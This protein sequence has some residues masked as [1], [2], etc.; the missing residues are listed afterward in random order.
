MKPI[1]ASKVLFIKLGR[2]GHWETDCLTKSQTV[3]LGY[4]K[5]NHKRCLAKDWDSI[6]ADFSKQHSKIVVGSYVNQIKEFYE[7]DETVLWVTFYDRHMWWCFS[8]TDIVRL[9]DGSKTRSVIGKWH[10]KSIHGMPLDVDHLAGKLLKMQAFR[11]T[12]CSVKEA[13]YVLRK[14]NGIES[15]EVTE[16]KAALTALQAKVEKLI[17]RLHWKD[18]EIL[19]DLIFRQAGWQ[20]VGVLGKT[21]KSLD[22]EL[23]SPVLG[24]RCF[25]Q[26]KSSSDLKQFQ[27]YWKSFA[28]M[29]QFNQMFYVVHSPDKTLQQFCVDD[30]AIHL[31][32]LQQV[33]AL[34]VSSGLVE[35]LI[36]KSF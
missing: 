21:E 35:W 29:K 28:K 19:V 32:L 27:R 12:I 25:V 18:F 23:L 33:A 16:A 34:T 3:R 14:I 22:M 13:E 11:G 1:T 2:K 10:N 5:A 26:I 6:R 8:E 36:E 30:P 17:Q 9:E 20:R 24:Q 31:L 7:A 15:P 4:S